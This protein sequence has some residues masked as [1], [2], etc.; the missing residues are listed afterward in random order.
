MA[1]FLFLIEA[2]EIP[3]KRNIYSGS[4]AALDKHKGKLEL[5]AACMLGKKDSFMKAN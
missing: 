2:R 5:T 1:L 4:H 3:G